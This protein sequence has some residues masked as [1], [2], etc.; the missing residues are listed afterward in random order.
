MYVKSEID[1]E[2]Y[3]CPYF[4]HMP[5][6]MYLSNGDPGYPEENDCTKDWECPHIDCND[7]CDA[8]EDS[9]NCENR[10]V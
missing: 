7:D 10:H 9:P 6:K 2:C 5:A 4:Q 8:C 1:D 3:E